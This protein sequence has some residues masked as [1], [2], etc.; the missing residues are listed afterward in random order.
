MLDAGHFQG[1]YY[2]MGYAVECALKA[3]IAKQ[4]RHHDFPDKKLANDSHV[5]DLEKLLNLA[6]LKTQFNAVAAANP[7]L[8]NHWNQ[9][10][11]WSE[12][13]RYNLNIGEAQAKDFYKA[14]LDNVNGVLPWVKMYW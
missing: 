10:R 2:L 12:E 13:F 7:L 6:Q 14:C 8:A 5:H 3:C 1:A 9:I 4:T 11:N